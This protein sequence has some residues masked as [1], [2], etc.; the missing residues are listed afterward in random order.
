[1][2]RRETVNQ[3]D[4]DREPAKA[5]FTPGMR[6]YSEFIAILYVDRLSQWEFILETI[7]SFNLHVSLTGVN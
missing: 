1:M 7:K 2:P 5:V 6:L 4:W 3:E